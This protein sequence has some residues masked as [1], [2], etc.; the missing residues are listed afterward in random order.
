V[1]S[2]VQLVGVFTENFNQK[3]LGLIIPATVDS[4]YE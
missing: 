4:T 2:L 3:V 1:T